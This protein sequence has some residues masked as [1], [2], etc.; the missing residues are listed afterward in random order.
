MGNHWYRRG[1]ARTFH[2]LIPVCF[3]CL[4]ILPTLIN[5][6]LIFISSFTLELDAITN[7]HVSTASTL[8]KKYKRKAMTCWI[9]QK[10]L[11]GNF[12]L[13]RH[14]QA[15]T[16]EKSYPCDHC[17]KYFA[18][19]QDQQSH[20]KYLNLERRFKCEQCG[21]AFKTQSA[22]NIHLTRHGS[23]K[24]F[25]CPHCPKSYKFDIK[26]R[27]HVRVHTGEKPYECRHCDE[28]F[29]LQRQRAQHELVKH[30]VG[31]KEYKCKHCPE[32]FKTPSLRWIHAKS[33]TAPGSFSMR[34]LSLCYKN[35]IQ[36]D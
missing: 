30:N 17:D 23:E 18:N 10:K 22:F 29:A 24:P 5:I 25:K 20:L 35:K 33:H 19:E 31:S 15:H 3:N 21:K 6:R 36:N 4:D 26:L 27:E 9:C 16:G 14:I 34:T 1:F 13:T 28:A 7:G 32:T 8:K 2:V 11:Y 12:A